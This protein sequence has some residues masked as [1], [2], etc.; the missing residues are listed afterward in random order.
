MKTISNYQ[1]AKQTLKMYTI[2]MKKEYPTD[3]PMIRQLINDFTDYLCRSFSLTEHQIRL[4]SD[5][6]CNLHPKN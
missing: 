4:L 5:Y 6:S 1:Q 2:E 3:K